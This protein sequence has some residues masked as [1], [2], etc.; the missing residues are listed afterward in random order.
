MFRKLPIGPKLVG[1]VSALLALMLGV[2]TYSFFRS[3]ALRDRVQG[4]SGELIPLVQALDIV[5]TSAMNQS[6]TLERLLRHAEG[7]RVATEQLEEELERFR[8]LSQSVRTGLRD[9]KRQARDSSRRARSRRDIEELA[10]VRA[11]LRTLQRDHQELSALAVEHL[12]AEIEAPGAEP[13]DGEDSARNMSSFRERRLANEQRRFEA[14]MNTLMEDLEAFTVRRAEGVRTQEENFFEL[15]VENLVL[16]IF[17]FFFGIFI[18]AL[19]TRR[20]VGP[21][22]EL[23]AGAQRVTEGDLDVHVAV[24]SEDEV[25]EL[26]GA[27]NQMVAELRSRERVKEA[28][29][30]YLDPR[31]VENVIDEVNLQEHSGGERRV[32]TVFF[33]DI[34]R[35]SGISERLT[36]SGLVKV[37]NRYFTLVTHPI[38]EHKGI[39]DKFIGDE[40]MAWW[41]PPFCGEDEHALLACRAAL[42]QLEALDRFRAELPELLGFRKGLPDIDV[43]IGVSTGDLVVGTIGSERSKSYTVMGDTVNLASRLEGVNKIYGT[44]ILISGVTADA[45][46]DE[47]ELRE[48][49]SVRVVGKEEVTH[50]FEIVGERGAVEGPALELRDHFEAGLAAYRERR[51]D[52]ALA[53]FAECLEIDEEDGPSKTLVARIEALRESPPGED[54]DGVWRLDRK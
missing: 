38:S 39:V 21:I 15:T 19:T 9:A 18:A 13:D 22:R 10:N 41:G 37:I 5:H 3:Q 20:I 1:L 4:L 53:S 47:L 24:T 12:E 8:E 23:V 26:A 34:A 48:V 52:E 33:L 30:K 29:G 17:A 31:I 42:A 50:L 35:F 2:A 16:A 46:A 11:T 49:D 32:M 36:P 14:G 40:V 43:R 54:W 45:V 28:F 25:G 7:G 51:W 44:R 27:F 6:L